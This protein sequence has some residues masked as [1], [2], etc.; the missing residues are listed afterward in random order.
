MH[1]NQPRDVLVGMDGVGED[2]VW[3][4]Q[5]RRTYRLEYSIDSY[6]HSRDVW[7]KSQHNILKEIRTVQ[8]SDHS[9]LLVY[10][11]V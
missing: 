5:V 7:F 10:C 1:V 11:L 6:D 2:W 9:P 3:S 8:K 4:S